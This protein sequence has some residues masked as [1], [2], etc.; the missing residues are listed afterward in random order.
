MWTTKSDWT[1]RWRT[2]RCH[3][4]WEIQMKSDKLRQKT[5][6]NEQNSLKATSWQTTKTHD[7]DT[8]DA[9]LA[10]WET[11]RHFQHSN[12]ENVAP[13][14]LWHNSHN[15]PKS[16]KRRTLDQ[17]SNRQ[18]QRKVKMDANWTKT[19]YVNKD[20]FDT[21]WAESSKCTHATGNPDEFRQITAKKHK[22]V[23]VR[24][25]ITDWKL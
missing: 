2:T 24:T 1:R 11:A 16:K 9:H 23:S 17:H 18:R 14:K 25:R 15:K 12:P 3:T 20:S 10:P 19:D 5:G 21:A 7:H 6:P 13:W 8:K 22:A 4:Q